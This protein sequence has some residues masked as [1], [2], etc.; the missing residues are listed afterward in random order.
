MEHSSVWRNSWLERLNEDFPEKKN[1]WEKLFG[2][3]EKNV[4]GDVRRVSISSLDRIIEASQIQPWSK[5]CAL[6]SVG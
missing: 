1:E 6:W 3:G 4:L 2:S 5:G